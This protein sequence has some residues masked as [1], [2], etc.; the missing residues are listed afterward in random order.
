MPTPSA[1]ITLCTSRTL[2]L[3][4]TT[5]GEEFRKAGDVL[6]D[7]GLRRLPN[8]AFVAPL[9]DTQTARATASALVHHAHEHGVTLAT[10]SR[11]YLG[12][13]GT[14]IAARLPG[15]W[16]AELQIYSH[17]EWQQDLWTGLWSA[18]E[19]HQALE[20]HLIPFASVLTSDA[21]TEL[22]L[23]ER[24]GHHNGYLI[25]ALADD[26]DH[27]Q[28]AHDDP[29]RPRSIVLPD[30]PALAAQAVVR[31]FLP[32]VQRAL[33]NRN[34][35]TVLAALTRIRRE[36]Q[37][38]QDIKGSGP[39]HGSGSRLIEGMERDFADH[40]WLSFRHVLEYAPPLLA[41]CRPS[42][43]SW[44]EDSA[45]LT[46]LRDALT[47]SQDAWTKWN[48]LRDELQS[49]AQTLPAHEWSRVRT[50]LGI[51]VLPAMQTWLTDTQ[52]FERQARAA[53]PGNPGTPSG[54][55][56]RRLSPR[57]APSAPHQGPATHH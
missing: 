18:G 35:E 5:Y 8:G 43:T 13:I 22:L 57:P 44:P 21:G 33:H 16:S 15:T 56:P 53:E 32:A 52:P 11:P 26:T 54:P 42:A 7:A 6:R 3:V 12:D 14:E 23:V 1:V 31:T 29:T 46:R 17:P 36:H 27:T 34:L 41:R 40:A 28:H 51:A 25:G 10:S 37:A 47:T 49:I 4:V 30:D 19:I 45:A 39:A 38:L 2:G 48:D 55:S 9:A 20:D 24:P 50:E